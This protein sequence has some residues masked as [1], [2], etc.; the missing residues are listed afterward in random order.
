MWINLFIIIS[1]IIIFVVGWI[2]YVET[3]KDEYK[4]KLL[5]V[6]TCIAGSFSSII[7]LITLFAYQHFINFFKNVDNIS[8]NL[9]SKY[10]PYYY[11]VL[12]LILLLTF[13]INMSL[14]WTLVSMVF[15][16]EI[17]FKST[18]N[19]ALSK[20]IFGSILLF[21]TIIMIIRFIFA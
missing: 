6:S 16:K 9:F 1:R 18:Q 8:K 3:V 4:L 20:A 13:T 2:L 12:Y 17:D 19:L 10:L 14:S 7:F 5:K 15:K 21:S 11:I